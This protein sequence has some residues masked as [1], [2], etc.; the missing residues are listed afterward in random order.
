[1]DRMRDAHHRVF[2]KEDDEE[3]ERGQAPSPHLPP[4]SRARRFPTGALT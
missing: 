4:A 3:T 1:M 2:D